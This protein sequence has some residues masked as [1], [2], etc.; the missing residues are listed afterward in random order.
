MLTLV[1]LSWPAKITQKSSWRARAYPSKAPKQSKGKKP[2]TQSNPSLESSKPSPLLLPGRRRCRS[3]LH[4]AAPGLLA[5]LHH[6]PCAS[7]PPLYHDQIS[8]AARCCN[9]GPPPSL[10]AAVAEVARR[11][12]HSPRLARS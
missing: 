6:H 9:S 1:H 11:H 7:P 10:V 8:S 12:L 3:F 2:R 4:A 5:R